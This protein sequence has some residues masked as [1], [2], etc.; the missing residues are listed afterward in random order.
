M[1]LVLLVVTLALLATVI[2]GPKL[3]AAP[4]VFWMHLVLA[5]GVMSLITAAMQHFVPVLTRSRG[6]GPWTARLPLLMLAAGGLAAAT[7]SGLFDYAAT[8]AAALLG[9]AGAVAMLVWMR[10]KAR[11]AL[12]GPHPGLAWYVAAMACLAAG[13]AAAALIP[14]LPEQ[15][16]A[17]RAFHLHIN[18][19]GFIGLT[20]VGTLQVL[21]PT[22]AGQPDP[23][24]GLRL[25]TDLK[26]AVAGS[27]LLAV[28]QALELRG[29]AWAGAALWVWVLGHMGLAWLRLHGRLI[30]ALH[31][32]APVLAAALFGLAGAMAGTLGVGVTLSVAATFLA[33][34]LFPLLTGTATQLAPVW[35]R[36]NDASWQEVSRRTLGRW[37]GLRAILFLFASVLPLLGYKCAGMPALLAL[38]WFG[39]PF[40]AWLMRD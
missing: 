36:P 29:L 25:R 9:L 32:A 19:Y 39:I 18:L 38:F 20:A 3:W 15:Y 10:G 21:M 27:L 30:F 13:L 5:A 14:W 31:G 23:Q 8:S 34:F 37:G 26:W 24:A 17:L 28:G 11:A 22:V 12:G 7:F 1:L 40:V 2:A 16:A 33:G 6:A 35:V 4:V